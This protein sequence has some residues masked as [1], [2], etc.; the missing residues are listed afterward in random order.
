MGSKITGSYLTPVSPRNGNSLNNSNNRLDVPIGSRASGDSDGSE[1]SSRD[2]ES[3]Y[4]DNPEL[5]E[6]RA[7]L[8]TLAEG[9]PT[10]MVH[11]CLYSFFYYSQYSLNLQRLSPHQ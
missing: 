7:R 3:V 6:G 5:A 1:K 8:G 2:S 9:P 4:R 10:S 11:L